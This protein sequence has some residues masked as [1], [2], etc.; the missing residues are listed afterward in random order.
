MAATSVAEADACSAGANS[1]CLWPIRKAEKSA[2]REQH[3]PPVAK[4][5]YNV[6]PPSTNS[7]AP[8]T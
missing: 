7:V 6:M 3:Y 1:V 5:G 8:V 2:R 4:P